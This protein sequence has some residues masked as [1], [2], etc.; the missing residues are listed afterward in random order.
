MGDVKGIIEK[1]EA[2]FEG[3]DVQ[4]M[5]KAMRSEADFDFNLMLDQFKMMRKM[6]PP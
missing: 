4:G 1:A 6:G 5:E 2:A 3:E